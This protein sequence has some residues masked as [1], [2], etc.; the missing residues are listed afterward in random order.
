LGLFKYKNDD[1][2]SAYILA[3]DK[4]KQEVKT[5]S[6]S[7][8]PRDG[9][10]IKKYYDS[11]PF[12]DVTENEK[13]FSLAEDQVLQLFIKK[14]STTLQRYIQDIGI[15]KVVNKPATIGIL[16]TQYEK[17]EI[18]DTCTPSAYIQTSSD[19]KH[20]A[21]EYNVWD[22]NMP[23]APE[24]LIEE[25]NY[26][27]VAGTDYMEGCGNCD[28]TGKIDCYNCYTG[29]ETCPECNG[30]RELRCPD[31]GGSGAYR[32]NDC[33]GAGYKM[34]QETRY[35]TDY[36]GYERQEYFDVK[37][38]CSYCGGSGEIVC[39]YC[40]GCGSV[41]CHNCRGDGE[42]TCHVCHGYQELN[43]G[44]CKGYG[45]L[46]HEVIAKQNYCINTSMEALGKYNLSDRYGHYDINIDHSENNVLIAELTANKYL[47]DIPW[48]DILATEYSNELAIPEHAADAI[49]REVKR[50][51]DY[52]PVRQRL[53]LY[54][55][56]AVDITYQLNGREF[57]LLV[58]PSKGEAFTLDSPFDD[59]VKEAILVM[60]DQI[61]KDMYYDFYLNYEDILKVTKG[62]GKL[63]EHDQKLHQMYKIV[64]KQF[65]A[66]MLLGWTGAVA[67]DILLH[68]II[69]QPLLQSVFFWLTTILPF[70][71]ALYLKKYWYL[72][73]PNTKKKLRITSAAGIFALTILLKLLTWV[74]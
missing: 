48:N 39:S 70:G 60:E 9:L 28:T 13:Y 47:K 12:G 50:I 34:Y 73:K 16:Q 35:V 66:F 10:Q 21:S 27:R 69:Q 31:C 65:L 8:L 19:R 24:E 4:S 51:K 5:M 74:L 40:G 54:Q 64:S 46:L 67:I 11:L 33:Y 18:Y 57:N 1:D 25:E 44:A 30:Y 20:Y 45:Y 2:Q 62:D 55:K 59:I 68:F 43:C 71:L 7:L 36:N 32:C 52:V 41:V 61:R 23:K 58:D 42:V 15:V 38:D 26:R 17:R 14:G 22:L 56:D 63:L 49:N 72:L 29:Y 3:A 37:E 6:D 53:T